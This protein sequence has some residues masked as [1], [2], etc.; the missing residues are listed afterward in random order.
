M[1]DFERVAQGYMNKAGIRV[2]GP[3]I[4]RGGGGGQ[5]ARVGLP[6]RQMPQGAAL[7]QVDYTDGIYVAGGDTYFGLGYTVVPANDSV[8]VQ[9]NPIRPF[10]PI[11]FRCIS[12]VQGLAVVQIDIEGTLFFANKN[13]P[14]EGMPIELFSE[15]SLM[16]GVNWATIQ[17]DTG[18]SITVRNDTANPLVFAGGFRGIQLRR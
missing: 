13:Q 1:N 3:Q 18:V 10:D 5:G 4:L 12:S 7:S 2:G 16:G 14:G 11:E 17:T 8:E 15:V 9:R 6:A